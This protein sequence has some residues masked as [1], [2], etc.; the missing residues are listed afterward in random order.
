[1]VSMRAGWARAASGSLV[2]LALFKSRAFKSP[3]VEPAGLAGL[4]RPASDLPL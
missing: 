3:G 2:P 4:C 1:M